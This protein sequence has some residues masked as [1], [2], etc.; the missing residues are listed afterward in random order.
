[1]RSLRALSL[2]LIAVATAGCGQPTASVAGPKPGEPPTSAIKDTAPI[3]A[4]KYMSQAD[5]AALFGEDVDPGV[6]HSVTDYDNH[7]SFSAA[8]PSHGAIGI[9][10]FTGPD[11]AAVLSGYKETYPDAKPVAGYPYP[12][13]RT[14]QV[15]S[16][17][18]DGRA[19]TVLVLGKKPAN[20]DAFAAGSGELCKKALAN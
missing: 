2:L 12:A 5:A 6:L 17:Q 8:N 19:C 13:I 9:H 1:M 15:F 14:A 3:D 4:C 20:P 11:V 18:G 10:I 7:C 16:A